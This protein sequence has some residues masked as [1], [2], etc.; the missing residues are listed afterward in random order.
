MT[1]KQQRDHLLDIQNIDLET[2]VALS[3]SLVYALVNE[4][5]KLVQVFG[6]TNGLK[7]LGGILD[8]IKT[9]GE[10]KDMRKDLP[11]LVLKILETNP[12]HMKTAIGLWVDKYESFGYAMYKDRSPMRLS[13]ETRLVF[14]RGKLRYCLYVVGRKSYEKLVGVFDRKK[15]LEQFKNASYKGD[16]ISTV[17]VH[18]STGLYKK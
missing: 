8:E 11:N 5:G 9:S 7:H 6:S 17:V 15:D 3:G 4:S 16:R 1:M 18:S 12:E 14:V 13:L 10:Y 2:L